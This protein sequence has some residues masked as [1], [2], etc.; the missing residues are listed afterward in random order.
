MTIGQSESVTEN[1]FREFYGPSSFIEK[2]AIN[3]AYGFKSK[4]G[5]D[6]YGYP[7][8]LK[9][10]E[11]F[12]IIVE[13]K[14]LRHSSAE[15]EIKHYMNVNGI[16]KDVIGIA[17]SGQ[18]ESQ[19]K[20]T[21]FYKLKDSDEIG[22]LEVKDK[23]LTVKNLTRAFKKKIQGETVSE[24]ELITTIKSLNKRFHNDGKVRSTDRSLFFSGL[25]IALTN[26]NF[27]NTYENIV[28]PSKE[29]VATTDQTILESHYLNEAILQAISTQLKSKIN[30]MSKTFSW[31]DKF[32]F[33]RNIDYSLLEY[34]NIINIVKDKIYIPFSN[35]EKQDILG[36]A[37]K[38]FLSRAGNAEN[39]NIILTPDHIKELMIKLAR[40]SVDDVVIDTCA[41][42]GGFLMESMEVLMNLAQDDEDK[43]EKIKQNQLIGFENDEVLFA[44][45]CSNMFLHGDG[46]S[47]LL[48]RSSLLHSDNKGKILNNKDEDLFNY[49]KGLKPTKSIINPPY[50]NNKPINFAIQAIDYIEQNGKLIIIMPTPTLT[51]NKN[52]L[53]KELLAKAK[54]DFVIKMP[55][56]LFAE[57]KRTVNTSVFGFTKTPHNVDDNVLFYN[58]SDD[59]FESIQH[60]GRVDIRNKWADIENHLL[61]T[62]NNQNEIKGRS[63]KKKIYKKEVDEEGGESHTLIPAGFEVHNHEKT[64]VKFSELFHIEKGTL[65]SSKNDD[66]GDYRFVT[67]ADEYK[68]HTEFTHDT[69]ALV[70]A[71]H[72]SGSLGKSQYVNGK[73]IASD[74]CQILT[75]KKNPDYEIDMQFYNILLNTIKDDVKDDLADGTAKLVIK[76]ETLEEYYIEYIPIK[77]QRDFVNKYMGKRAKLIEELEK[78]SNEMEEGI[79]DILDI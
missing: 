30:N 3:K 40:L 33:I 11:D 55:Y 14:P 56:S 12:V 75:D 47:N 65:Q 29:E 50:E 36:K 46:R 2:S 42:S 6:Y 71:T 38:I 48:Y 72:A 64:M 4:R 66:T 78:L 24:E 10:T 73:F 67:A 8:F 19:V 16:K 74:L 52:G 28:P 59:G 20:V 62:I 26:P 70:Y 31:V 39:K 27:R 76:K 32:S 34:K 43:L 54:L 25:M 57:Q 9:D 79:S 35:E 61:D 23:M 69:E 17:F 63:K 68:T 1:I 41:G 45:A 21:Y 49:I 37:Y 13:T 51:K 44:L 77:K 15:E 7:D 18:H 58:L 22:S 5:S 60:K 53:T